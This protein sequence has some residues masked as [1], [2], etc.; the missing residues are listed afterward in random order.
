MVFEKE[1]IAQQVPD[2]EF[3]QIIYNA[4]PNCIDL[5][6]QNLLPAALNTASLDLIFPQNPTNQ[7]CYYDFHGLEFFPMLNNLK[8]KINFGLS[9]TAFLSCF[10]Y[11]YILKDRARR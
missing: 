7:V 2:S 9:K 6:T 10:V 3:A 4:C 8:I 5:G 11:I 1:I